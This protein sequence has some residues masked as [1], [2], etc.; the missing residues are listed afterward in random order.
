MDPEIKQRFDVLESAIVRLA[1]GLQETNAAVRELAAGQAQ[2]N[3]AVRELAAGQAQTNASVR[4][5]AQAQ[6]RTDERLAT[7]AERVD[8]LAQLMTRGYT[9]AAERHGIVMDRLDKLQGP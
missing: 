9:E 7:L 1:E 5:L 4:E 6:T 2:T 8:R 3:A